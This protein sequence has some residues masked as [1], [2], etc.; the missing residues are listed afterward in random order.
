MEGVNE[1]HTA[2]DVRKK[3]EK[4]R[5]KMF[6]FGSEN[7]LLFLSSPKRKNF[8]QPSCIVLASILVVP[9]FFTIRLCLQILPDGGTQPNLIFIQFQ[10]IRKDTNWG[11][12]KLNI[13]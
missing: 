9:C 1:I 8:I 11:R 3:K 7:L 4:K 12:V 6:G 2:F 10:H 5:E 13:T